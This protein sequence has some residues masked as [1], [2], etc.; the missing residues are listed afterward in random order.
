MRFYNQGADAV[1]GFKGINYGGEA[2]YKTFS[3]V[4]WKRMAA[5]K[6]VG[7]AVDDATRAAEKVVKAHRGLRMPHPH[8]WQEKVKL[9]PVGYGGIGI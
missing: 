7:K 4:F 1:V 3:Q 8:V 5:G 9:V 2:G 6:P